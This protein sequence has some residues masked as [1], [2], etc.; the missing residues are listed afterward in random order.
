M[1]K[2]LLLPIALAVLAFLVLP[3]PGLSAP[4]SSRIDTKR[5]Q[6]EQHKAKEGVLST[7]IDGFSRRI[8][9]I[10]GE[11]SATERRLSRVQDSLDQ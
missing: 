3:M 8:D 9:G 1:K 7:T 10:Q 4:L 2:T 11:I 6:I 5:K